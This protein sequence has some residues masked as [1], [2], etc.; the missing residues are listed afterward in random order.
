MIQEG[1]LLA[2]YSTFG[3]GG[4]AKYFVDAKTV[5]EL[6]DALKFARENELG[7]YI[8]G[9]GSNSI[10][11]DRGFN[12]LV[13]HNNLTNFEQNG[14]QFIVGAG[15]SFAYLGIRTAKLG[16][17]GLE[18]AS[19]IPGS[20][21]GAV[22]MNAGAAGSEVKDVL[23][24][25][26][27]LSHDGEIKEVEAADLAFR[28]RSSSFHDGIGVIVSAQ[29][30]LVPSTEAKAIQ[31]K[32]LRYRMETQPL[33]AK[34]C[35]CMFRNPEGESAGRLIEKSGLK[36]FGVGGVSVSDIH[37]N[38]LVNQGDGTRSDV[39]EAISHIR[40]VVK[41]KMGCD[42]KLEVRFVPYELKTALMP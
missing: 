36:G 12:G 38:F 4:E 17:S 22:F 42:L 8:L 2:P 37:A 5:E 10:F 23:K 28:Y 7:I 15:Y 19:G 20:V 40:K 11:D 6:Q 31:G 13:I 33:K 30:D 18:F 1:V 32:H 14:D 29:F 21:G 35:G 9:K 39:E 3:I 26:T 25:V 27:Y 16:Y 24:R 34:S 41:A